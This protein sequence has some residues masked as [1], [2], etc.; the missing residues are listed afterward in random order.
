MF[1]DLG[2]MGDINW[3]YTGT[4]EWISSNLL[5]EMDFRWKVV[6]GHCFL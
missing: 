2:G 4:M 5:G 6:R 3:G 1:F